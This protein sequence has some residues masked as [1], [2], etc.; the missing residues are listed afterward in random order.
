MSAKYDINIDQGSTF[1]RQ[2]K[3][4]APVFNADGTVKMG[5]DG[6]ADRSG[7]AINLAGYTVSSRL[8]KTYASGVTDTVALTAVI[9][10]AAE[11]KIMI[12]LT[13][14]QTKTLTESEYVYDIKLKSGDYSIRIIEGKA[15]VSP[16]VTE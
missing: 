11:G 14:A 10:A 6:Q 5:T 7:A 3:L 12:A 13:A 9:T 15:Y 4:T 2:L 16:E 1:V 8:K